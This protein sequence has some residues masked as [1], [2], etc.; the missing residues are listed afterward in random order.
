M[1][2]MVNLCYVNFN[3]KKKAIIGKNIKMFVMNTLD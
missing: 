2:K 3:S 1:V